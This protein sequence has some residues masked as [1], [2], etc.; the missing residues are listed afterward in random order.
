MDNNLEKLA[1][2]GIIVVIGI[3]VYLFL[4]S[5]VKRIFKLRINRIDVRRSKT[6]CSLINNILKYLI[7]IICFLTILELYNI[8]TKGIITS[9]GIVGVVAGLAFQD[10]LKDF[11]A[12]FSIIFENEY[13]VGDV[14]T[15]NNFKGKVI[16]LG[17]KTTKIQS[18]TG[19]ILCISNS[20]ITQVI[21]HSLDDNY[22]FIDI[23]I[24]YDMEIKKVEEVLQRIIIKEI[25]SDDE[26]LDAELLG[27]EEMGSS[28]I[29]YRIK[30]K[31]Q[32]LKQYDIRRRLLKEIKIEFDKNNIVIP[33]NQVVVH[34]A[35]I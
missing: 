21:N 8:S 15:V 18:V 7:L 31:T 6:I 22:N 33:Y 25:E 35:R 2:V 13:A 11:L 29:N 17:L 20:N 12:G 10:T 4:S 32:P 34:N 24:S 27:I 19:E 28:S 1:Y 16:S 26:L 23:P 14:I 30:I 3:L 5:S 9:L